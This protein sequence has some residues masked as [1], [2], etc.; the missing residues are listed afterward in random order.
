MELTNEQ[1]EVIKAASREIDF[2]RITVS[3]TGEPSYL[4]DI[5]AEKHLRF[6]HQ[7]TAELTRGKPLD[8]KRSGR[9]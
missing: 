7:R 1:L 8:R 5:V 6:C 3:F 2:G 9:Y 4:V